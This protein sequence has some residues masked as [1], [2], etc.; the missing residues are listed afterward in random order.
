MTDHSLW[1]YTIVGKILMTGMRLSHEEALDQE[2]TTRVNQRFFPWLVRQGC[3]LHQ[4]ICLP[5]GG[6]LHKDK[7]GVFNGVLE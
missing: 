5:Q 1:D 3:I 4:D 6:F 7:A 2:G